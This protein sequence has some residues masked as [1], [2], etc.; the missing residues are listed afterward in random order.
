[1]E[2]EDM[3]HIRLKKEVDFKKLIEF[4]FEEDQANC[5]I[6]DHYY[7][8][9]NYFVQVGKEFRVT[10]NILDRHIDVLCLASEPG[11][12]NMFNIK[13]LYD[14]LSSGLVEVFKTEE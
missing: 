6:G 12:H 5:E 14:L 10:V 11:L 7:H 2:D 9:N 8:L 4:G 13:P 3:E 1:M